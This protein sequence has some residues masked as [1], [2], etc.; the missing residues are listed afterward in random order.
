VIVL[1]LSPQL[2]TFT[3]N[4]NSA[5]LPASYESVQAQAVADK[6]F[7][8]VAGASGV[9]VASATD[10]RELTTADQQKVAALASSLT[11]DKIPSVESV[12]TSPLYLSANKKVQLVEVVF[13]GH[14]GD[15]G[16]NG[17]V[18]A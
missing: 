1:A 4:N 16:P 14:V 18:P 13:A 17:A 15:K 8:S 6:Y 11:D 12:T 5:F 7:P 10:G 9:I 3:S 2:V